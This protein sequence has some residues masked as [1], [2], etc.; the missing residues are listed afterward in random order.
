MEMHL[1]F[2]YTYDALF[3]G[4]ILICRLYDMMRIELYQSSV[5][6]SPAVVANGS[7]LRCSRFPI[8]SHLPLPFSLRREWTNNHTSSS[9]L[10]T[11][12]SLQSFVVNLVSQWSNKLYRRII[13][14]AR[15][16]NYVSFLFQQ[17]NNK[18]MRKR[19]ADIR[20]AKAVRWWLIV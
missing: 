19:T 16:N 1:H 8:H 3:S 4:W 18:S 17:S 2:R 5:V 6:A 13:L 12:F 7:S 15:F 14:R 9:V 11:R 10:S 20:E